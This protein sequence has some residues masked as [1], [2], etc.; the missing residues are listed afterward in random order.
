[1]SMVDQKKVYVSVDQASAIKRGLAYWG[2]QEIDL[3]A[4][5][6]LLTE[7][8]RAHLRVNDCAISNSCERFP[9]LAVISWASSLTVPSTDPADVVADIRECLKG[10]AQRQ[11]DKSGHD[12]TPGESESPNA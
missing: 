3:A 9:C 11:S 1:M 4:V 10:L 8:E 12:K 7:D 2:P 5:L 6:A